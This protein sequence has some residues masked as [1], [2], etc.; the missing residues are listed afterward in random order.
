MMKNGDKFC[1]KDLFNWSPEY[2][3]GGAEY[4]KAATIY[5][6]H[7][8][9]VKAIYAYTKCAEANDKASLPTKVATALDMKAG[10]HR[11][12]GQIA[13]AVQGY[14]DASGAYMRKPDYDNASAV[15]SKAAKLMAD[16]DGRAACDL[17]IAAMDI[18]KDYDRLHMM[19]DTW[20]STVSHMMRQGMREEAIAFYKSLFAAFDKLDQK[21]YKYRCMLS[22]ILLCLLKKDSAAAQREYDECMHQDIGFLSGEEGRLAGEFINAFN[23]ANREE[24]E[25]LCALQAIGFLE[26]QITKAVRDKA[27]GICAMV[28]EH[29]M[30]PEDFS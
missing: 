11:D 24:L 5:K 4:E 12:A 20:R 1:K 6:N 22:I 16:T 15:L 7:K 25:R 30:E 2:D 10:C 8:E 29:A 23:D 9:W 26:N 3:R 27:T 18:M 19:G 17:F 13:E 14:K 21:P 28:E